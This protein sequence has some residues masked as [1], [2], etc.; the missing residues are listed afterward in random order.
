MLAFLLYFLQSSTIDKVFY[1]SLLEKNTIKKEWL[2]KNA[3]QCSAN[4]L[5]LE[6]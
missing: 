2:Y 1:M 6:F 3:L 4:V 5:Y